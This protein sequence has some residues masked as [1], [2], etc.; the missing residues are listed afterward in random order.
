L[1]ARCSCSTPPRKSSIRYPIPHWGFPTRGTK[2]PGRK[3]RHGRS[4][5]GGDRNSWAT[6]LRETCSV[7]AA[8]STKHVSCRNVAHEFWPCPKA[9]RPRLIFR[10]GPS[11]PRVGKPQVGRSAYGLC[12]SLSVRGLIGSARRLFRSDQIVGGI[13]SRWLHT[14]LDVLNRIRHKRG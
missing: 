10:P 3:I 8:T 5:L 4:A 7:E 11:V 13:A 1:L 6:F 14:F 9:C 2:G 12:G